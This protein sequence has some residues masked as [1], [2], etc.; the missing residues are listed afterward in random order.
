MEQQQN[1]NQSVSINVASSD[2]MLEQRIFGQVASAGRQLARMAEVMGVL[3]KQF[4][5]V[6]GDAITE[7]Q[8]ES[9]AAFQAMCDEIKKE[10][11]R[12]SADYI[13]Q[14]LDSLQARDTAEYERLLDLLRTRLTPASFL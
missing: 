4:E 2:P 6:S 8:R 9:I 13:L 5:A 10:K 11:A 12:H 14:Q 3:I 1:Q 7:E